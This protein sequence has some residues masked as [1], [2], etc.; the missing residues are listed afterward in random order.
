MGAFTVFDAPAERGLNNESVERNFGIGSISPTGWEPTLKVQPFTAL[1]CAN[2]T[3][4]QLRY[5]DPEF[6]T[7]VGFNYEVF[8]P[9]RMRNY[10]T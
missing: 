1:L 4:V 10:P 6:L 2:R 5:P 9:S 7:P 8:P 3:E